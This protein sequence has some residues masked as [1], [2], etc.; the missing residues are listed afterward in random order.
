VRCLVLNCN[1]Q[2]NENFDTIL[3]TAFNTDIDIP[4]QIKNWINSFSEKSN[5]N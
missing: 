2:N 4:L 3:R 1:F 5:T